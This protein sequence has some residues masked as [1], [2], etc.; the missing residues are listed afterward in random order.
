MVQ[1]FTV[2]TSFNATTAL[3]PPSEL[4][5]VAKVDHAAV[6]ASAAPPL[7]AISALLVS[8]T[9]ASLSLSVPGEY[10]EP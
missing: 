9:N 1:K 6:S 2:T 8:G 5:V 7:L 4:Q 10:L 3:P